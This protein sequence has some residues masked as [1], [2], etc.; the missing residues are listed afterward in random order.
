VKIAYLIRVRPDLEAMVPD[1]VEHVLAQVGDDGIYDQATLDRIKDADAFV[2]GMEPVTAQVLDAAPNVRIA[3]RLG[4]GYETL[5]LKATA[6]RN[7]FACNIEGV[8]KEAVGEHG[9]ALILALA[10]QLLP[11][12]QFTEEAR[13]AEARLLSS[14]A[15]ELKGRTLGVIGFG[16]T[17]TALAKRA[18]AF[19]MDV[20]F[21]D[22]RNIDESIINETGA[23][24]VTVEELLAASDFVS[25][26]TDLNDTTRNMF[27]HDQISQMKQDARLICCA[28]GGILDEQAVADALRDGRLAAAGIDVFAV[29]PIREDNPL[30]SLPNCIL[31][32]HV[33]GVTGDT[34]QRIWDWA[35]DNV[36]A[37]ILR[38]ERPQWIRNGL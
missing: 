27:G 34:T 28:R 31:T 32:S 5:D 18:R 21:N 10:K 23:R 4:V 24:S 37:V 12:A 22:T 8:N 3:Q 19:E 30:R 11:A 2:I 26:N 1:D 35:H 7:V 13:W 38:G 29:E 6:D 20:I 9:M 17:G 16:N 25:I 14:T 33:A 36:R 15:F